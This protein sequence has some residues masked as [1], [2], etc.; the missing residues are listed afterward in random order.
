MA[1]LE[2]SQL[3]KTIDRLGD[4]VLDPATWPDVMQEISSAAAAKG[5]ILLQGDNRTRD[6]PHTAGVADLL[7][8]YFANGLHTQDIRADRSVPL[9]LS[10][11]PVVDDAD[12]VT[13]DEITRSPIYNVAAR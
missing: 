11:S 6:V 3:Q 2:S 8:E 4:T 7:K 13:P 12:I 1:K 10:G 5:A 9:L